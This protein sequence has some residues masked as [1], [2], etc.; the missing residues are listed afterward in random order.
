MTSTNQ[1]QFEYEYLITNISFK[2]NIINNLV[3]KK[4]K[5]KLKELKQATIQ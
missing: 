3:K 2:K 4:K 5:K 1:F